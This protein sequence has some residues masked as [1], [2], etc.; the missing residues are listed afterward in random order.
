MV[1]TTYLSYPII[2]PKAFHVTDNISVDDYFDTINEDN[3][4]LL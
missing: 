4:A 1:H 3:K 2:P